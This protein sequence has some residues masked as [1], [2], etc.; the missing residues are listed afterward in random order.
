MIAAIGARNTGL[1][2]DSWHWYTA[3][4][5]AADI[6]SLR[7]EEIVSIDLNDAPAGIPVSEQIDNR[8]ELP[9]ATGVIPISDFLNALNKLGFDGPIRCEPFNAALRAMSK[10][11]ALATVIQSMKKAFALV[12]E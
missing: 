2:L 8:R 3:G 4:E 10:D 12:K 11:Q 9:L 1:L 6:E 7:N 5:K